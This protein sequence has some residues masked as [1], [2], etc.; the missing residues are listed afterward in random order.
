MSKL[1]LE[2][3]EEPEVKLPTFAGSWR[4][5][6]NSRKTSTSVSSIMLRPLTVWI[7]INCEK[8]LMRWEYQTISYLSFFICEMEL[9][10]P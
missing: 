10:M 7:I 4:K 2:K 1:G 5:L 9:I 8:L 3:E 6:G